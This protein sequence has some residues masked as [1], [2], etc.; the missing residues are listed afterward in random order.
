[1][2]G[3]TTVLCA[4]L[5]EG[6]PLVRHFD[7]RR[8]RGDPNLYRGDQVQMVVTGQGALQC[9]NTLA[10]IFA[11]APIR[12]SDVWLNFGIAGVG[13]QPYA[14]K[15]PIHSGYLVWVDRVYYH[16]ESWRLSARP[17]AGLGNMR[18]AQAD[19]C[20]VDT[21]ER[22]FHQPM[23]YDMECAAIVGFLLARD[24]LPCLAAIKLVAD[25]PGCSGRDAIRLGKHLLIDHQDRIIRLTER[26]LD[27]N[28]RRTNIG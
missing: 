11:T 14:P 27:S 8:E 15:V 26:I 5:A 12:K 18:L 1:M 22:Q 13:G 10:R 28:L 21:S 4:H 9:R 3:I 7:L 20:T 23:I 17:P 24:R 6:Q 16:G 19:L 2:Q 25:G